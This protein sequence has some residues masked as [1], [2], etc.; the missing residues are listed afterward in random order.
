MD[1]ENKSKNYSSQ[2]AFLDEKSF[3]LKTFNLF[4][5]ISQQKQYNIWTLSILYLLET[6]QL[7]S[8]A[9]DEPHKSIWRIKSSNIDKLSTILSAARITLLMKFINFNI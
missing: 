5:E 3:K 1:Y 7:I 2:D 8:Y 4:Y 6:I 9:F